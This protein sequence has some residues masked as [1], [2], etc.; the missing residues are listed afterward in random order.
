MIWQFAIGVYLAA[1][2][3]VVLAFCRAAGRADE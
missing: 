2:L 1:S 3:F